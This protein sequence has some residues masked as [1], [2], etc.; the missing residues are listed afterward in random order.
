MYRTI[1]FKH[2]HAG[3]WQTSA[4][5][6]DAVAPESRELPDAV[7][8]IVAQS[9]SSVSPVEQHEYYGWAFDARL[10]RCAFYTVF[11]IVP[12]ECWVT[13]QLRWYWLK[14]LLGKK[15]KATFDRY[16][17]ILEDALRKTPGVSETAW[18]EC[19]K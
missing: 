19:R 10:D 3:D 6:G 13:T 8:Q 11:N 12:E 16:C 18:Q 15:P 7:A 14:S 17:G 1:H 9:V 5:G 4:E 2:E